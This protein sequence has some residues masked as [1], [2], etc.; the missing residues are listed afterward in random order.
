MPE[1]L[2]EPERAAQFLEELGADAEAH[3]FQAQQKS[4]KQRAAMETS[5]SDPGSWLTVSTQVTDAVSAR[6]CPAWELSVD[7]R[8]HLAGSLAG[9]LDHY[10]PGAMYGF[11]NWHPL[12]QLA[13][14][15]FGIAALR[16]DY[17][18]WTFAPLHRKEEKQNAADGE[19]RGWGSDPDNGQEPQ[20]QNGGHHKIGQ[21]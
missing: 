5:E 16:I 6:V 12:A 15:L 20:R 3:E 4:D 21:G 9:V 2:V 14:T 17:A 1:I 11:A 8:S 19:S 13:G 18:T 7:E 10:F